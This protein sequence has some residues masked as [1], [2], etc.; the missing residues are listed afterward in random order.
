MINYMDEARRLRPFI[1]KAVQNLS[2][3]DSLEA[4]SLYPHWAFDV[5]Y[6]KGTKV[7]YN[8]VLYSV[9][10]D[11]TS[12]VDWMPDNSPSL[13]AKVLIPDETVIPE[14]EQ[15]GSTNPYMAGDKVTHGGKTWASTVDNNVWEP[16]VY[17]WSEVE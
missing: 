7:Q 15:P 17:G 5:N 10:L 1:E 2:E 11:H 13:F 12:Q 16:G 4:V 3:S 14:W 6:K 9:L 8:G